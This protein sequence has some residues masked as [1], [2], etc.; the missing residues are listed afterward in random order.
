MG[1]GEKETTETN[2]AVHSAMTSVVTSGW[3]VSSTTAGAAATSDAVSSTEKADTGSLAS[4]ADM[5]NQPCF[6]Y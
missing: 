4:K 6:P 1:F 2:G 3:P 5:R